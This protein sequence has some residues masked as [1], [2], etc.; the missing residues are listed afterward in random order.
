M[1][2]LNVELFFSKFGGDTEVVPQCSLDN[3]GSFWPVCNYPQQ[4]HPYPVNEGGGFSRGTNFGGP[5]STSSPLTF[6]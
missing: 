5:R 4:S 3:L 2:F 1:D 6:V